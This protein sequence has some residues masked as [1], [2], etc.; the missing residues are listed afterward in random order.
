MLGVAAFAPLGAQGTTTL[1]SA[2]DALLLAPVGQPGDFSVPTYLT[3]PDGDQHRLFV[4]QQNGLIKVVVDNVTQPTPFLNATSWVVSGGEEGLLSLA[5]APDYATSGLFYIA[6]TEANT[7]DVRVDELHVSADPNVADPSSRR[8]VIVVPHPGASN[9][10]GGQLQFGPDG[11][12]YF[13]IGDGGGGGDP[14]HS[15]QSLLDLR[16]K[17]LRIDPR[18]GTNGPYRIPPNNP[19][20]GRRAAKSEIWSYGLRNPWRF[21]FD[22]LTDDLSIGDVGQN[23]WE[24]I[25]YRPA[26]LSSGRGTNFG[27]SCYEGR[28]TVQHGR[29][30]PLLAAAGE[31]DPTRLRVR[32]LRRARRLRGHGRLRD[33][34]PRAHDAHRQVRL[35]RL[36]QR[37]DLHADARDPGLA[38]RHR[39]RPQRAARSPRSARTAAATS[40]SSGRARAAT[41]S[42]YARPTR[43]RRTARR[44]SRCRY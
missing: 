38:G 3:A 1:A 11:L 37:G 20:V 29:A 12:L 4:V 15:A 39:H 35:Q 6:Y 19:F 13:G 5:F 40:T 23:A 42:A 10:N 41:S 7:G 14:F 17:I 8:R 22:R 2:P 43:R 9:H 24:E 26:S 36:L 34:R 28:H 21:S 18:A 31:R 30:A 16:G 27:W 33:P 44:S 25:D 32:A